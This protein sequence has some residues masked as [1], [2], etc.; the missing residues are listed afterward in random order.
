M[1]WGGG[2]NVNEVAE[3]VEGRDDE[4]D[5]AGE[6]DGDDGDAGED[7]DEEDEE[8]EVLGRR[9]RMQDGGDADV[10]VVAAATIVCNESRREARRT[11]I[12]KRNPSATKFP[13][14]EEAKRKVKG[15]PHKGD[16]NENREGMKW[17]RVQME[18]RKEAKNTKK[19]K[20]TKQ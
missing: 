7:G 14:S 11:D 4:D 13:L 17:K 18:K 1:E 16:T 12:P 3:D 9:G 8:K 19:K 10:V 15:I 6:E 5:E 2:A 20:N